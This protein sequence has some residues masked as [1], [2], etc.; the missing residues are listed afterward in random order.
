MTPF[1]HLWAILLLYISRDFA[2]NLANN[3]TEN[4]S[5]ELLISVLTEEVR[6]KLANLNLQKTQSPVTDILNS[7]YRTYCLLPSWK[8]ANIAPVP[9]QKPILDVNK[10]LRPNFTNPYYI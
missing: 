9:K 8:E 7:S 2:S 3:L 10:H 5:N 1:S 6:M 4:Q